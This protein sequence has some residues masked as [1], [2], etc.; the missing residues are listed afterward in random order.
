MR[1]TLLVLILLFLLLYGLLHLPPVQT[2]L[3][4][5][6]TNHLSAKLKTK[7]S[8]RSVDFS[9]FDKLDVQGLLV[10]DKAKDTLLYAGSAKVRITDWFF[11][12][13]NITLRYVGLDHAIVN[14]KRS[15]STWNYQF[16]VD[17]FVG[18]SSN[19]KDTSGGIV[20]DF[21]E[22]HFNDIRFNR[23]DGWIGQNMIGSMKKMDVLVDSVDIARQ[24]IFLKEINFD[25]PHFT[26][27]DYA[28]TRPD[29]PAAPGVTKE[30]T[31]S[32][33]ATT[34]KNGWTFQIKKVL[35]NDGSF[36]NDQETDRPPYIDRFDGQH[37]FISSINGT[38]NDVLL[39]NDTLTAAVRL[40]A[41]EKSGFIIKNLESSIKLTSGMMEFKDLDLQTKNSHLKNY[42]AMRYNNFNEDMKDFL[43]SVK[44][45]G[46]FTD[47]EL[48]SDDIAF[49]APA[50]SS[51]KR[52]FYFN[53]NAH[54]TID[55]LSAKDMKIKSGNTFV[56]GDLALRGLPDIEKTFIDFK[57]NLL[58]TTYNDLVT[59]IPSLKNI[60]QPQL[61]KL[62]N[63]F[64]KGNF[65]GF[66]NDF[67][68]YGTVVSDL[69]TATTDIN[70]K[71]PENAPPLYSG[72][73]NTNNFRLGAFMNTSDIGNISINGSVKGSGFTLKDLNANFDGVV[74]QIEV[75][76]YNFQNIALNGNFE[77]S[78]FKGHLTIDDPNLKIRSLEGTLSLAGKKEIAFNVL[79]DLEYAHLKAIHFTN[80]DFSLKGL[81]SLNFTGNNIDNFL[82][83]ARVYDAQLKH[84]TTVLSFDSLTLSSFLR[85]DKKYLSLQ[86]NQV[87]AELN[88][89]FKILELPDAFKVFLNRYYPAY[90]KKPSY[91]V[92][93]QDFNFDI[94]TREIDEYIKLV[95]NRL[96]G[97]NNSSITGRLN[98]AKSELNV[99][100]DV[101]EFV[102][103]GK[104]FANV[105]LTGN[106]NADTLKADIAVDDI[107]ISD[108]LHFPGTNLQLTAHND[109]SEIH[110]KTSA[111][112]TLNDAELN[113]S[114][115]TFA[116][117]VKIHFSPS[118]F[119]INDKKWLLENDGEL[120][121]RNNYLDASEIKFANGK[122]QISI[123]TELD[124]VTDQTH[125][126]AKLQQ[127]DI[128]DFAPFAVKDPS[129]KGILTGTAVV[130]DPFG[131]FSLEFKGD[132]DSFA[133]N[134]KYIGKVN[135]DASANTV[136]GLVKFKAGSEE[137][138]NSFNIDGYYNYKD[139]T[140]N[141]LN[142]EF[143]G[144]KVNINILEP[145]LGSIFSS[146]NGF[147]Q[148]EL[149]I[150][151]TNGHQ[152]ITGKATLLND[153]I[154]IGYTQ[155][156]YVITNQVINFGEDEI[157]LGKLQ[158]KDTLNHDGT[159]S[160]KIYHNFFNDLSFDKVRLETDKLLL[161]H[162]TQKDNP[163]FYGNVT[164][165][166]T[167]NING[168][169]TN[170]IMDIDGEPSILDSSHIYLPTGNSREGNTVD[171]IEF[172][173]FG[174]KMEEEVTSSKTTNIIVN[175][176][177][178]A[179]PACKIDV[180]L[181]E[182]TGDVIK[183]Q[184]NGLIKIRAGNK[185]PLSIRGKY[186]LTKG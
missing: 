99:N 57:G 2:W 141:G 158:L 81:F 82:G 142:L 84:D 174:S 104:S 58:H 146:M 85:D 39:K 72:R 160:G 159:I 172:I 62:G 182:E 64:Y 154:Q 68:T 117:G 149:K 60:T 20:F 102:Y 41:K 139:S 89:K 157:D 124:D 59:I 30:P 101:P 161:L 129:L 175:L 45:E 147:A 14:M 112:K 119:I 181:D 76:G 167:L 95:D 94:K 37:L 164:G 21:K 150:Y 133:L 135:V 183:G 97:F 69:G 34:S 165:R 140:G 75:N 179:N 1:R 105:R 77:K 176:T 9:F 71:F 38:I 12:K 96:T 67:V 43:H 23:V 28:G 91:V 47:S 27:S 107:G 17:Y 40:A 153:T 3:V 44:L 7:V 52:T 138:N 130:R 186:E 22:A 162:T 31:N 115:Q 19:K 121:V 111:G 80:D 65:T 73:I 137:P 170:L 155:C 70:M 29:Q 100:A 18:P 128:G 74:R 178:E 25:E 177:L 90:I 55:N 56:D 61:S 132:A 173:Q 11:F 6:V 126:V 51:W 125:I 120:T 109:V 66:I 114:I 103:A 86:S 33:S 32:I 118:S 48:N 143:M 168:P 98:L 46:R 113:A 166:A 88:G 49:F 78:L 184:G 8:L 13:N 152:Y 123:S 131:R 36:K 151:T 93:D 26:L 169:T 83:T 127:V 148:T 110:L 156:K 50:L 79:A 15:D 106:G 134:N 163:D 24:K 145:Y 5:K 122:Q 108:S 92:S 16:L 63:I 54:G 136:T 42:Y 116:D 185:E 35:L 180:I 171:Y 53:G 10:M 4:K 144:K 87:D